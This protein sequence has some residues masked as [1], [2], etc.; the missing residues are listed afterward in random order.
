MKVYIIIRTEEHEDS[1]EWCTEYKD[2]IVGVYGTEEKAKQEK[3]SL[4]NITVPYKD[5]DHSYSWSFRIEE[6]SVQ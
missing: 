4:E 5:E 3:S 2:E 6:H 1:V